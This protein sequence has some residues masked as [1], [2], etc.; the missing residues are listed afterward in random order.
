[1]TPSITKKVSQEK[2]LLTCGIAASVLYVAMCVFVPMLWV[3]YSSWSHTISELSAVNAPTRSLWVF[4]GT[5]YALLMIAFGFGVLK[6]GARTR[7]LRVTGVLMII[8]GVI[9]LLWPLAPMH[10]RDVLAAG[11]KTF[12]DTMHIVFTIVTVTVMIL[13]MGFGAAAFGKKFRVYTILTLVILFTFGSL[14]GLDAPA[15]EA[16][17]PTPW[18]GVWER[19][20]V[21]SFLLWVI[22][23]AVALRQEKT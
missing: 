19:V 16:N 4:L 20:N 13:A 1:M 5:V 11:G 8:Y 3:A 2:I 17:L 22:I 14:T 6:S 9:C 10:Q 15:I 21:G 12:S 7:P 23:L 18:A